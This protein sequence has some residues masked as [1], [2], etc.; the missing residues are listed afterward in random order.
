MSAGVSIVWLVAE[1]ITVFAFARLIVKAGFS[2]IW[3]MV[4]L[5]P[6]FLT[7]AL[8]YNEVHR[9]GPFGQGIG[10]DFSRL[11]PAFYF[12]ALAADNGFGSSGLGVVFYLDLISTIATWLMFLVFAFSAWPVERATGS[13]RE[14]LVE[15]PTMSTFVNVAPVVPSPVME[16]A[17]ARRFERPDQAAPVS[18]VVARFGA[19]ANSPTTENPKVQYCQWCAKEQVVNALAIHHCG[20]KDRPAAYCRDCGT[21]FAPGATSCFSCSSTA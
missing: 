3:I 4:P 19:T 8:Y 11:G 2:P 9:L 20:P 18:P 12:D 13:R 7:I 15:R 6:I 14:T 17:N 5:I 10:I 21:A 1:I 16:D